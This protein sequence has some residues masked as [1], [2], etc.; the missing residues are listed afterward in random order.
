MGCAWPVATSSVV[1]VYYVKIYCRHV[2]F[3]SGL[4]GLLGLSAVSPDLEGDQARP[5]QDKI[6]AIPKYW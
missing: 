1:D 6:K 4:L 5:R 2:V 3:L